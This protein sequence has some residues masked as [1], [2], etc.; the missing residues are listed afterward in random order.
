MHRWFK[1]LLAFGHDCAAAAL[2]FLLGMGLR[3]GDQIVQIPLPTLLGNM[4]L[5][6]AIC[7]GVFL[8]SGLYR[9]IW[10]YASVRDLSGI[11]KAVTLAVLLYLP[12]A[13]LLT[14]LTDV[15]RTTPIIVWLILI[16]LLS[17]SRLGYRLL[18]EKR[19]VGLWQAAGDGQSPVLLYG[20]G[21]EADLFIRALA[22]SPHAPYRVVGV[23]ADDDRRVG[24]ELH[25]VPVLGTLAQ[26]PEIMAQLR[27]KQ[28]APARLILTR[29]AAGQGERLL[30]LAQQQGLQLSRLPQ[31]TRLQAAT[32]DTPALAAQQL[33]EHPM[34]PIA[35][36]DLLGRAETVLERAA[37]AQLITNRRV[38]V[39]GGGGTIG[40]E[41]CR[42]IAALNPAELCIIDH[43]ELHL[44]H[45]ELEL[46]ETFPS[47]TLRPLLGDV[48]DAARLQ[49][50]FAAERPE[51][52]FHA[53]ALKHVPIAEANVRETVL[54]NVLGTKQVV[55]CAR[56]VGALATVLISTDKA[57]NPTNVM[58]ATKRIAELYMQSADVAST[59]TRCLAVRFGNVLGST[60]SVVPRFRAQL[61][62]G[63]PL[64]VTHPEMTR[65]FMTVREAVELVLQASAFCTHPNATSVRGHILVLDMG[66]PVKIVD[67]ARQMIRLAGLRPEIDIQI[68]F[69]GLR[70]GEKMYEEL[71]GGA[72]NLR[73]APIDGVNVLQAAPPE[74]L[75]FQQQLASLLHCAIA[76]NPALSP[77]AL[78]LQ[79]RRAITQLVPEFTG[80]PE[81]SK[82]TA[83]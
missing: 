42:Q 7:G 11:L 12:G 20:A 29:A 60:G 55:D 14:R 77:E 44:Y 43:S 1:T 16:I 32:A 31:M 65:Y 40:S 81:E 64:T 13:F 9:G 18:R 25:G 49:M 10:A 30:E 48:R 78:A 51:L 4:L 36:E 67:L 71:V 2:A 63:G 24:R 74:E 8:F 3:H 56:A 52:V 58:G 21:D 19:L 53:A 39:T 61:A 26:L 38:L 22:A 27:A 72:E 46:R 66:T 45:I 57:V 6:T 68:E 73:P 62:K 82:T 70:P 15:P 80:L 69:T 79:L 50:L 37:I 76:A 5:F 17:G 75:V 35:I 28:T 23:I 34:A 83:A 47:L 59:A 54:T 41:L 33:A